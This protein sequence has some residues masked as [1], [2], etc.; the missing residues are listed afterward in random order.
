[1][2]IWERERVV[3]FYIFII[4]LKMASYTKSQ[5][6]EG[7]PTEALSGNKTFTLTNNSTGSVYFTMETVSDNTGSFSG[8]PTNAVGVFS[9]FVGINEDS[10][11]S[12]SYIASVVIP[13]GE[14]SF[15]FNPTVDVVISSSLLRGTGEISL[16]I[17]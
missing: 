11:V 4:K 6:R 10:L 16:V 9:S 2:W 15:R 3:F 13:E 1:M 12:S 17:T 8:K 14:S 7:T 5:L